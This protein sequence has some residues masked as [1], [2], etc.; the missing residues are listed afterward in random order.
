MWVSASPAAFP[1]LGVIVPKHRH[2][3]VERNRVKRHLREIGRTVLLPELRRSGR[4][5]D[6]LIRARREAYGAGWDELRVEIQ[7]LAEGLC[8]R[9]P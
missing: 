8:S 2:E 1:R 9:G 4:V 6:V 7:G 3:I 5:L